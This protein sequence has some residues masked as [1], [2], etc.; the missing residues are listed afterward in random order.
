M[1]QQGKTVQTGLMAIIAI[2]FLV[3][4]F[5]GG[6]IYAMTHINAECVTIGIP[7]VNFNETNLYSQNFV[8][9]A[10]LNDSVNLNYS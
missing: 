9:P 1:E 5:C 8:I 3:I 2:G 7:T 4:G 6:A 10:N